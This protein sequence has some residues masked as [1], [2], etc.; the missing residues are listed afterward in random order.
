MSINNNI[1][2]KIPSHPYILVNRSILCNCGIEAENNFLLSKDSSNKII[3]CFF[4]NDGFEISN[5]LNLANYSPYELVFGRKPKIL[6]NSDT[7]PDT[8]MSGTFKDY[9]E[10][11]NK[12]S[13]YLH[14]HLQNIKSK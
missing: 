5:T 2:I 11:L 10:L 8:S 9:H 1:P 7:T 6:F 4:S 13:K 12:R 3:L 14:E